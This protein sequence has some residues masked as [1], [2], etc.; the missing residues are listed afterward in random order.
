MNRP[1]AL[2]PDGRLTNRVFLDDPRLATVL[3][4]LNRDGE[5]ARVVGGAVRNALL[6]LAPGDIDITTTATPDIVMARAR[7]ARLRTIP[8]GVAHGTVTVVVRG[9]PLE[10]TTLRE[11]VE[12]DGRHAVVRFGR[13]F[14]EDARRRDFTV[15]ALSVDAEGL[16]HDVTGGVAD[17]AAGRVRFIGDAATRIRE[18]YLRIL[19]FFRFSASYATGALDPQGLAA[20]A[21]GVSG[22]DRLSR[23]RVRAELLKLLVAPRAA[24]AVAAMADAGVLTPIV[25]GPCRPERL[26]GLIAVEATG[27]WLPDA[28]RRLSALALS[29]PQ[30]VARLR[31]HLR[32]SNE[33]RDRLLGIAQGLELLN[34]TEGPPGTEMVMRLLHL[35]GR[36]AAFDALVLCHVDRRAPA[37]DP[38][39]QA[40]ARQVTTLAVPALPVSG[41]DLLG[42]GFKAGPRVGA[43]LKDVQARWIRARFPTDPVTL[44]R[45]LDEAIAASEDA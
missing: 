28:L 21:A 44:Q 12:T 24:A 37:G 18:D 42:R 30:D 14:T 34:E 38:A 39:W 1:L 33:E 29:D 5:S 23:E 15:N 11:D 20:C 40:A 16:V 35:C 27:G 36:P 6:G 13:D 43:V 10:V 32:L 41:A 7:A 8:T 22:L 31:D 9:L 26:D 2:D 17:L 45:L 19:R 25:G 4:I 3:D